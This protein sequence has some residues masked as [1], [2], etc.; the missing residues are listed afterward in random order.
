MVDLLRTAVI[1]RQRVRL[2]YAD[3]AN[4]RTER[5]AD[6]WGLVD[7]DDTWY[8]VAGTEAGEARQPPR[9]RRITSRYQC[10]LC[11]GTRRCVS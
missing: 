9:T 10:A 11:L 2:T 8:L 5:L 7:K 4:R 6:P 1:R 3:H